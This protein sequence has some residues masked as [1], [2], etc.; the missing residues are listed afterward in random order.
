[1]VNEEMD[2]LRKLAACDEKELMQR[3][4]EQFRKAYS[5]V[6]DKQAADIVCGVVRT[7]SILALVLHRDEV[8]SLINDTMF[9]M[10]HLAER[11]GIIPKYEFETRVQLLQKLQDFERKL[12]RPWG[13]E[14]DT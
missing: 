12:G 5:P 3:H 2:L 9:Y 7:P 8:R 6:A 11:E 13:G 1:M 14:D 10:N 4:I